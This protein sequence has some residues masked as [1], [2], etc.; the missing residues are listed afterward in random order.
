[1]K[2]EEIIQKKKI[3]INLGSGGV[4]KTSVSAA[5][6]LLAAKLGKKAIVLTIDPAK[7]LANALGLESISEEAKQVSL[8][9]ETKGSL[10]AMM[11]DMKKT[12]DRLMEKE[13]PPEKAKELLQNEA[14][15]AFSTTLPG[16][17]E[18]AA[19]QKVYEIQNS[20]E[21]DFIVLDTP[22]TAH[23]LDFLS[24]PQKIFDVFENRVTRLLINLYSA[25]DG[26]V[27]KLFSFGSQVIL[28]GLSRFIGMEALDI[29]ASFL[30]NIDG[31]VEELK[32]RS[33]KLLEL[34]HSQDVSF[35]IITSLNPVNVNEAVFFLNELRERGF[36]PCGIIMNRCLDIAELNQD[37]E[38]E[39][40][41]K[42]SDVDLDE[43]IIVNHKN[44]RQISKMHQKMASLLGAEYMN[45][46]GSESPE[47]W[48]IEDKKNCGFFIKVPYFEKEIH[49]LEGISGLADFLNLENRNAKT[50]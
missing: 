14:Y 34:L 50:F 24:S 38:N 27:L 5:V 19:L 8:P 2:I 42:L 7:R 3:F 4:G 28:K 49:D 31:I 43:K 45:R 40:H 32:A 12:F 25:G 37:E 48:N 47:V 29:I 18:F 9:F 36:Y 20:G 17:H 15:K 30:T 41:K 1:M 44:I 13:L 39:I 11:L 10:T 16:T 35:F 22:P 23:A 46:M 26:L 33:R 6:A 21:Y